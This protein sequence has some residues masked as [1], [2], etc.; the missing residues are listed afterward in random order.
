MKKLKT[1]RNRLLRTLAL[2]ALPV[3]PID[4]GAQQQWCLKTDQG[5]FIEMARVEMLVAVDG[6]SSFEVVVRQG[7]GAV[8][9]KS[10]TFELHES[11]YVA[12]ADD[13]PIID[14]GTGPWCLITDRGDSIAMSRVQMLAN[15]DATNQFEVVTTDGA[16]STGVTNI[17]FARGL[18]ST[19]GGFVKIDPTQPKPQDPNRYNPWCM[20]TDKNDTIAM[21]RIQLLANADQT[22][23]FEIV[24]S[25]GDNRIG[26]SFVRFAHG[27]SKTAGGFKKITP[28]QTTQDPNRYNPWCMITDR[29]DTIAMSRVQM[30][31][32]VDGDGTFEIVV[33]DG[34]NVAG[35]QFVRFA[36]GDS[37]TAGGFQKITAGNEPKPQQGDGPWCLITD[38]NDSIAMGRV[39]MLANVDTDGK[40]EIVTRD[41]QGAVGVKSVRFARGLNAASGGFQPY[42]EDDEPKEP[43]SGPLYLVTDKGDQQPLSNVAMLANVDANGKFEVVL[44]NGNNLAGV[45]YVT[46]SIGKQETGIRQLA[47]DNMLRLL[48]PVHSELKLSG[49]GDAQTATVY[50]IKGSEVGS[51]PVV[52]G[53]TTISVAHLP[54]AT[55]IVKVGNKALKFIKK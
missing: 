26:I 49:C 23:K 18:S 22:G 27:D 30:V 43:L 17:R 42:Q 3:V 24:T 14:N 32:N 7:Q 1:V 52:N 19:S 29:K 9:V 6:Q 53:T 44:H 34:A 10:I 8:G 25:D 46:F 11:D 45:Q 4:V 13:E 35:A 36:H 50:D 15:V 28:G 38:Q 5:Q 31:A 12:P 40:F 48:T 39:Q 2:L 20:I 33:S 21:S 47:S 41:G 16:N 55:Y 37:K 54:V 51:A